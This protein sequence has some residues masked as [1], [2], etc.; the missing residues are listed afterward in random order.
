[1]KFMASSEVGAEVGDAIMRV[2]RCVDS[3]VV[4]LVASSSLSGIDATLI[5]VPIIMPAELRSKYKARSRLLA[6]KRTYECCPQLEHACFLRDDLAAHVAE[7]L[8]GLSAAAPHLQAI[9]ANASQTEEFLSMLSVADK[10]ALVER[11]DLAR[12]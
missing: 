9:G 6:T 5:Y 3:I 1:M 4:E 12:Q 2:H 11:R 7:Y 10:R 8:R